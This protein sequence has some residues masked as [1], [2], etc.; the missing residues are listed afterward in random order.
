MQKTVLPNQMLPCG[1][2]MRTL[3]LLLLGGIAACSQEPTTTSSETIYERLDNDTF[4]EKLAA[5]DGPQLL[6]VR[7]AAEFEQGALTDAQRITLQ[8][9]DFA[10]RVQQTFQKDE[11]IF[12]YC[13]AGG[14]S[15]RACGN[16]RELGFT[17][18]YELKDGY[19]NWNR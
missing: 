8:D 14:R 16:L 5:T 11:P 6:D 1:K 19:G 10:E 4:A 2:K 3:L 7:T 13:Q 17:E 18:I 15:K 12:V 9:A